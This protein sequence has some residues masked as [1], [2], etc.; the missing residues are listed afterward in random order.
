[1]LGGHLELGLEVV[2]EGGRIAEIRPHTGIPENFVLSPAFINAHSHLEYRH[3]M[4]TL[5]PGNYDRWIRE[6]IA[7]K[8]K[9]T[10]EIVSA[11]CDL[12]AKENHLTGVAKIW[13]HSDR[14]GAAAGMA[15]HSVG[16]HIFQEVLSIVNHADPSTQ[17]AEIERRQKLQAAEGTT[18]VTL[19]PHAPH[20]VDEPTLAELYK[21]PNPI[22]THLA[23]SPD[24]RALFSSH[25][26][27]IADF[28]R[29]FGI[30]LP[31]KCSGP[32]EFL[33]KFGGWRKGDQWV[34]GC[35]LNDEEIE[36]MA[37]HGLVLAHCPRSN[38]TLD[39]PIAPI[40]RAREAGV[41]VG[42]GLDSAAS[43][44]PVDMF[45]EMRAAVECSRQRHEPISAEVA[46]L[47]ATEEGARSTQSGNWRIEVGN[48]V[49]LIAIEIAG[50]HSTEELLDKAT[51]EHV[52][53]IRAPF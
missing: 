11:A 37:T 15:M 49:P 52:Q 27:P 28:R 18:P 2:I 8:L 33:K 16:G 45:A 31:E 35:D 26:G 20:T 40:R 9:D 42:L 44:G 22:S 47:M 7:A 6:I 53:W 30:P 25:S 29:K 51:P 4:D 5:P 46:W 48:D 19:N 32:V 1:M 41:L 24:E 13:E 36:I 21:Q 12:A 17:L 10:P 43:S 50:A 3:M 34:H 39:C 14:L 23:E 38:V